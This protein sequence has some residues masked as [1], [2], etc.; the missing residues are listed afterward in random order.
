[1]RQSMLKCSEGGPLGVVIATL[2][3]GHG[4]PLGV[5]IATPWAPDRH[6]SGWFIGALGVVIG[7]L[8]GGRWG[9]FGVPITT[10]RAPDRD[11]SGWFVGAS[12]VAIGSPK[13][14]ARVPLGYGESALGV[15]KRSDWDVPSRLRAATPEHPASANFRASCRVAALGLQL[16][17]PLHQ[18]PIT[19]NQEPRTKNQEL[20]T[21]N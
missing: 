5:A 19:S 12:G 15:V 20:A 13:A 8:R 4:G 14:P 10:P 9:P 21:N 16:A 7:T 3:G 2:G 17:Y 11:P 1:M 6:P 18:S